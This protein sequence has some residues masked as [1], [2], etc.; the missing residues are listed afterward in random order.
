MRVNQ[1]QQLVIHRLSFLFLAAAQGFRGAMV[2]VIA[3]EVAR[4]AAQRFL[5][6]G[7]LRDD[8]RAVAVVFHHFLQAADLALD[9]AQ[10]VAVRCFDFGIDANGLASATVAGAG[11]VPLV[12]WFAGRKR[13]RFH[14]CSIY[15]PPL[16]CKRLFDRVH[17]LKPTD[18][19]R[20]QPKVRAT[21]HVNACFGV[22]GHRRKGVLL[23]GA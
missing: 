19:L 22:A 12:P 14:A 15:P 6:A 8:V 4:H 11:G 7:D 21:E 20:A 3:H 5:H 23:C 13:F 10:A 17:G 1:F 18:R 2:Q 9:A 16:Y